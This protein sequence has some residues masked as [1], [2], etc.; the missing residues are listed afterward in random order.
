MLSG[1]VCVCVCVC[2]GECVATF[3][4]LH[5]RVVKSPAWQP[6][7]QTVRPQYIQVPLT[8]HTGTHLRHRD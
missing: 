8:K 3:V 6:K 5:E 4:V 2:L 1:T 7:Y